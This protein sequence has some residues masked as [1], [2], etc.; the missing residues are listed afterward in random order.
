[1][2]MISSL[3]IHHPLLTIPEEDQ[4]ACSE[5]SVPSDCD[6][7][8]DAQK[9]NEKKITYQTNST[10]VVGENKRLLLP[11]TRKTL[12]NRRN[13]KCD[14]TK[15]SIFAWRLMTIREKLEVTLLNVYLSIS[16]IPEPDGLQDFIRRRQ[17]AAEFTSRFCRNYLYQFH[18]Q[19]LA[20][21]HRLREKSCCGLHY[22]Y[23]ASMCQKLLNAY[24]L[25][26]LALQAV[27]NHIPTSVLMCI[28]KKLREFLKLII[29]LTEISSK[30]GV[31]SCGS[32][33]SGDEIAK[34]CRD[35]LM[36]IPDSSESLSM[37]NET[38]N[39]IYDKKTLRNCGKFPSVSRFSMYNENSAMKRKSTVMRSV[40][41]TKKSEASGRESQT[42]LESNQSSHK[43]SHL[44]RFNET[45]VTRPKPTKNCTR[46]KKE[47]HSKLLGRVSEKNH[48]HTPF[49]MDN[50]TTVIETISSAKSEE[51]FTDEHNPGLN[52]NVTIS[53]EQNTEP[54]SNTATTN[55]QN[56]LNNKMEFQTR[57]NVKLI[58]LPPFEESDKTS[59]GRT[60]GYTPSQA[61]RHTEKEF[62]NN[63]CNVL[64]DSGPV[65]NIQDDQV[66]FPVEHTHK[67][68]MKDYSQD[69]SLPLRS[70]F[71]PLHLE[72]MVTYTKG[73]DHTQDTGPKPLKETFTTDITELEGKKSV[74]LHPPDK[75][76]NLEKMIMYK[77]EDDSYLLGP[78]T[79]SG[80]GS[81]PKHLSSMSEPETHAE[82][83]GN[84]SE[85]SDTINKI[86]TE[87]TQNVVSLKIRAAELECILDHKR[88]F[89]QYMNKNPLYMNSAKPWVIVS[90]LADT[91]ISEVMLEIMGEIELET[92]KTVT[93]MF[94]LELQ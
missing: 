40:S 68:P 9:S 79:V 46:K 53:S 23:K 88:R 44:S 38:D 94:H 59:G 43:N 69:V 67:S 80:Q 77:N 56:K 90:R 31:I 63:V 92:D 33:D 82:H 34:Y 36:L 18:R 91:L 39:R 65:Q 73:C 52:E 74:M 13:N 78:T 5:C 87:I 6:C 47:E 49:N 93:Q 19:V 60:E 64:I 29:E 4:S 20:L 21:Q 45:S 72:K 2:T 28:P 51:N 83:Q 81:S 66:M 12:S 89:M 85:P 1:M 54:I 76:L 42:S 14:E 11:G 37:Q 25:A 58:I 10:N 32:E 16:N 62:G 55:C 15:D 7:F 27:L 3:A 61:T 50:V 75:T 70:S 35:L 41:S 57:S 71:E 30:S 24:E 84:G 8:T 22:I 86:N 17:R 26:H 48:V